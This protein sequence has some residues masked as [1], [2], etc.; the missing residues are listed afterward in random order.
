[1]AR[2]AL[3]GRLTWQAAR[4]LGV[5]RETP[6]A[7]RLRLDAADWP[8]HLAG[9][10]LDVRL[11]APDGYTAQRS[12]S[13][14]TAWDGERRLELLVERL[15]D[16]EVSPYLTDELRAG[17][18]LE[19]RGPVGRYFVLPPDDGRPV[20]LVAGGSGIVPFLAMLAETGADA[21]RGPVRVLCSAR[22]LDDLVGRAELDRPP[23]GAG[24]TVTLTGGAP[25]GWE[26]PTGRIDAALL[27]AHTVPATD[28]PHVL[29]CGPTSFVEHVAATLVT[30][31]HDASDI[32]TERFGATAD[33]GGGDGTDVA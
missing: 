25:P 30:L 4:V 6:R 23:A 28:R 10:H 26:G 5:E 14:A 8:G 31:G 22:T 20:Q 17:D 27:A 19:V 9:Q 11:T 1:M 33:S 12:Y 3:R 18:L 15:D 24:V 32:R 21:R 13:I 2:A 7:S 16:G 29:V